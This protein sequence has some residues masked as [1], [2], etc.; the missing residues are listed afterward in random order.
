MPQ[1]KWVPGIF[2]GGEG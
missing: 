2:H 1:Q